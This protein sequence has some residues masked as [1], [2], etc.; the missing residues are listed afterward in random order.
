M[1]DQRDPRPDLPDPA[2]QGFAVILGGNVLRMALG[3]VTSIVVA[4]GL[5]PEAFGVYA[6]VT[7]A[8]GMAGPVTDLG[9]SNGAIRRIAPRWRE[10]PDDARLE[11]TAFLWARIGAAVAV[12]LTAGAVGV[13]VAPA[14]LPTVPPATARGLV[15]AGALGLVVAAAVG[16]VGTLL[17]ATTRLVSLAITTTL[18]ALVS[19]VVAGALV[20]TGALTPL[21]AVLGLGV[22]AS[23]VGGSFA[24]TRLPG[25]WPL[26]PPAS[27]RI[28][29]VAMP[30]MRFGGWLWLGNLLIVFAT[31]LDLFLVHGTLGADE[32]GVYGLAAALAARA[33]VGPHSL[34][35]VL[36]PE[37]SRITSDGECRRY[38]AQGYRQT[39][40]PLLALALAVP[41]VPWLVDALYGDAF[42][43]AGRPLQLLVGSVAVELLL[44]PVGLLVYP[45]DRPHLRTIAG[46]AQLAALVALAFL[47]L[48]TWG[49]LGAAMARL[50]SVIV[51]AGVLAVGVVRALR[52]DPFPSDDAGGAIHDDD[53]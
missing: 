42:A 7:T 4:R 3:L 47:L 34:Y 44:V 22:V 49:I 5:G 24:L 48:P 43:G 1:R 8:I 20:S 18:T 46:A 12:A 37:A 10:R 29:E 21:T 39:W 9:L 23:I 17:Q 36:A 16:A 30:M 27:A 13:A 40:L 2:R 26:A 19:L 50:G 15:V 53:R 51:R 31:Q 52:R 28:A 32:V 41:F 35:T 38:L 6:L 45:L 14:L 25:P 33:A 11:G